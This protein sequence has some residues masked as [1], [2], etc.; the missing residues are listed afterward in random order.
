MTDIS[1][2]V[3]EKIAED[4]IKPY[5]RQHFFLRKSV[6]WVLFGMSMLLGIVACGVAIFLLMLIIFDHL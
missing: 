2:E 3:L 5:S 6:V 1:K 4:K